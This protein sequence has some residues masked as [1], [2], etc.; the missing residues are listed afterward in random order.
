[1]SD[2]LYKASLAIVPRLYVWLTRLWF[3][4]CRLTIR[5]EHYIDE[6]QEQGAVIVPFWHYSI[7]YVFHHLKQY[8]GVALVSASRDGEYIARIAERLSFETVRGSSHR[9]GVQALKKLLQAMKAGKHVGI[10][11]DGSQGPARVMQ[12]GAV[13]LASKTCAPIFPIAWAAERCKIFSS[14]DR[15]VLPMPFSRI[16]M[17]YGKPMNVPK[18]LDDAGIEEYR[19]I[20]EQSLNELYRQVWSE[21]GREQHDEELKEK[22]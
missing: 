21:F 18:N 17:R 3:S 15:T 4:T 5:D 22:K 19:G 20:V 8:P 14:W 2:F 12:P 16:V 13:Y 6:A 9:Q 1:L 7:F 10:V 11:A